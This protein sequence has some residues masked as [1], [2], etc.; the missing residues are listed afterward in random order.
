MH[1]NINETRTYKT[2]V[3]LA[4][5]LHP[6]CRVPMMLDSRVTL[7]CQAKGR[8]SSPALSHVLRGALPYVLGGDIYPGGIHV[9]SAKNRGDAPSRHQAEVPPPSRPEP[10]WLE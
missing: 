7:G 2:F 10:A 3:K 1:I 4:S 5:R 8:S 6:G 9:P